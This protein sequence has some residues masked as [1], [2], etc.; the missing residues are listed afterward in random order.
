MSRDCQKLLNQGKNIAD[1]IQKYAAD[2]LPFGEE[3][4]SCLDSKT[5]TIE[6]FMLFLAPPDILLEKELAWPV[7][8]Q[9][10][11]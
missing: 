10:I 5:R 4:Y 2:N 6:D 1:S 7:D 8:P 9:L 11:Y 3:L